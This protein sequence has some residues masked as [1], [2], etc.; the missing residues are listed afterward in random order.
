MRRRP[1]LHLQTPGAGV[2]PGSSRH[3]RTVALPSTH[4][5]GQVY[6]VERERGYVTYNNNISTSL[7]VL[8]SYPTTTTT[9]ST[10]TTTTTKPANNNKSIFPLIHPKPLYSDFVD[11]TPVPTY[12]V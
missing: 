12:C 4:R 3:G 9:T 6:L 11:Q 1:R 5:L 7:R 8:A 2:V 10:T